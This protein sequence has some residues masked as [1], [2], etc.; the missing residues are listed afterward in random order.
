MRRVLVILVTLWSLAAFA[1]DPS[2]GDLEK[3]V[4]ELQR[5]IE[6][7]RT[8]SPDSAK[9]AELER[10][11]QVLA[12]EI[13]KLKL[14]EAAPEASEGKYGLGPS[15]SKIYSAKK[16]V[17]FG[18]YGEVVYTNPS[19][20]LED[21]SPSGQTAQ[22]DLLRGVFYFG[23]KFGDKIIFNSE[24][25]VEHATTGE[26]D[27]ERGEVALEFAYL[28]FLVK[29]PINVRAGALLVPMGFINE[30]HEP[31]TYLGVNRPLVEQVIIPDTWTELGAGLF[32]DLGSKVTYRAYVTSGLAA[33]AGTSSGAGGF[34]AEGIRDGRA[35][36]SYASAEKL[37]LTG[38]I[39]GTPVSG[40]TIGASFFTGDAGQNLPFA[41]GHLE[42]W[43]TVAD[44]HAEY[45]WR[46][47]MTRA[48]YART[49]ID[50]AADVNAAQ[51]L[52]GD[53]SVGE[54][55]YGWYGEAGYDV[56]THV[57]DVRQALIPYFRYE[58]LNTQ[59]AVPAG[60]ALNPANDIKLLTVGAMWKP[61]P[62]IA[63]KLDWNQEKTGA[64]TGVDEVALALGFMF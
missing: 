42:A 33:A 12:A 16:G 56:L 29:A 8:G 54:K 6:A 26:G 39:D 30:R 21:G 50:H 20:K 46:G 13:E 51:D 22:I 4:Q 18:G 24:L 7:L 53:E 45:R 57:K 44:L 49:S 15:A 47:L 41:G 40:L 5:Q 64:R 48:L 11:I 59:D 27:E 58:R 1:A 23:A 32:G 63:V 3:Q 25:E 38:R 31:P 34:S 10:E 60:F 35:E 17:S 19:S 62:N 37:A 2:A 9:I 36:G 61:I 28:D 55:Q 43:T 14:G 52:V